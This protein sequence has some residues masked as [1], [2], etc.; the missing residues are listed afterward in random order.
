MWPFQQAL[1]ALRSIQI[2][3]NTMGKMPQVK[4]VDNSMT[5]TGL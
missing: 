1:S 5:P 2:N 4:T 3:Q